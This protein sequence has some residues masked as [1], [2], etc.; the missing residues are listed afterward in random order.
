MPNSA[1]NLTPCFPRPA[2]VSSRP[3]R[4]EARGCRLSTRARKPYCF[5]HLEHH[6]Y[7]RGLL[8][9]LEARRKELAR[10]LE[11]GQS[12]VD[13]AGPIAREA[14]LQLHLTGEQSLGRLGR[15]LGVE[16]GTLEHYARVLEALG[17]VKTRRDRWGALLVRAAS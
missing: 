8:T 12:A 7:V 13:P 5:L 1:P 16:P 6:P 15:E 4:C 10:V 17:A 3:R 2:L 14:L 9:E 11:A